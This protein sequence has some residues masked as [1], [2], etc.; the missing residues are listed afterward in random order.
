MYGG[1][2]SHRLVGHIHPFSKRTN[3]LIRAVVCVS[4]AI[5]NMTQAATALAVTPP[6]LIPFQAKLTDDQRVTVDDGV[7]SMFFAFYDAAAAGVCLWSAGNTDANTATIDCAGDTPDGTVSV[8]VTDG[9]FSLLLG[10]TGQNFIPSSLFADTSTVY[11]GLTISPDPEM[12]PRIR[13]GA[14]SYALNAESLD[15]FFPSQ[16]GGNSIVTVT[17]STGN[18]QLTNALN[19]DNTTLNRV[20]T[21]ALV[22]IDSESTADADRLFEVTS[23][24]SGDETV[25]FFL[26]SGGQTYLRSSLGINTTT[27]DGAIDIESANAGEDDVYIN[28]T[29]T[30]NGA[31]TGILT[32]SGD[33]NGGVTAARG[34]IYLDQTGV[35]WVNTSVGA[36]GSVWSNLAGAS[37]VDNFD[38]VYAESIADGN[39][40]MEIDDAGGAGLTFNITAATG[41]FVIQDAGSTF[42]RF[43]NNGNITFGADATDTVDFNADISSDFIPETDIAFDLGSAGQ[44]WRDLYL[45]PASLHIGTSATA[46]GLLT[47]TDAGQDIFNFASDATGNADIAF[48][49]DDIYLDKSAGFV[50]LGDTTPTE[51]LT[52]SGNYLVTGHGIMGNRFNGGDLG[53]V[54]F[55]DRVL[56]LAEDMTADGDEVL[57]ASSRFTATSVGFS[58]NTAGVFQATAQ[59]TSGA[60]VKLG[61]LIGTEGNAIGNIDTFGYDLATV[62]VGVNGQVVNDGTASLPTGYSFHGRPI[63][64]D[65]GDIDS[66]GAFVV[67]GPDLASSG[68]VNSFNGLLIEDL[69]GAGATET[70]PIRYLGGAG[71]VV[72]E[73]G[74]LG[75]GT[76]TPDTD[77]LATISRPEDNKFI[78]LND[79]TSGLIPGIYTGTGDPNLVINTFGGIGSIYLDQDGAGGTAWVNTDGADTWI[80]LSGG[81][82][83]TLDD[84][85]DN[86]GGGTELIEVDSG[87]LTWELASASDNFFI[88][89]IGGSIDAFT[90]NGSVVSGQAGF[91][92]INT[93]TPDARLDVEQGV[94]DAEYIRLTFGATS[95]S[96]YTGSGDPNGSVTANEGSL[97]LDQA[98]TT[99]VNTSAGSGTTWTDLAATGGAD[100]LDSVYDNDGDKT[101]DVDS[102]TGLFFD[103]TT[104]GDIAIQDASSTFALF[105]DSGNITFGAD[106]TDTVDFNADIASDFIPE[107][108][109][110]YDLGSAGQRW[111][112]LYLG[113]ATL[114]IGT[115]ATAEGLLTYTDAGQDIFNFASDATGNADIAFFV[116]DFYL[117]K[118]SGFAGFGD[119]T[120]TENLTLS[121]DFLVT[122]HGIMG[123]RFIGGDLGEVASST[124]VFHLAED[125]SADATQVL[126]VSN[127]YDASAALNS[128]MAGYFQAITAAGD[129]DGVLTLTGLESVISS[130]ATSAA[131]DIADALGINVQI[132]AQSAASITEGYG[133]RTTPIIT[134][135]G[136]ID[137]YYAFSV[138]ETSDTGAGSVGTFYGL[139]VDDLSTAASVRA[140]VLR[141]FGTNP[142]VITDTS[143][144]GIGTITPDTYIDISDAENTSLMRL[145]DETNA[146]EVDFY[147]G[148]GTPTHSAESGSLYLDQAGKAWVNSS[149]GDAGTTWTDL[150]GAGTTPDFDEVYAQSIT[151]T[152]LT[153]EVDDTTGLTFDL[154]TT[155]DF[156]I[157]DAGTP[158]ATFANTG[159]VGIGSTTPD[160][161]LD[162]ESS[163]PADQDEFLRFSDTTAGVSVGVF[164]G[165]GD[166][167]TIVTANEGSL[168]LDQAGTTWVNT[169]A[170]SGTTWVDLSAGGGGGGGWT[171]DGTLVRLTT[172]T[173]NVTVGSATNLSAQLATDG[174]ADEIQLLIQ[175]NATQTSNL[176]VV[177]N[178]G[179]ATDYFTIDGSGNGFF[180]NNID[181]GSSTADLVSVN[182]LVDT[183]ILPPTSNSLT[184]GDDTHRW[185]DLFVQPGSL[186]IGTST[187]DEGTISYDTTNNILQ[188]SSTPSLGNGTMQFIEDINGNAFFTFYNADTFGGA[189]A[190]TEDVGINF[191]VRDT[192]GTQTTIARMEAN[193]I[194]PTDTSEDAALDFSIMDDGTFSPGMRL[195][196]ESRLGIG[197]QSGSFVAPDGA[198]TVSNGTNTFDIFNLYDNTSQVFT[199]LDG[200]NVGI[201]TI[202]PAGRL[203]VIA[204]SA[205]AI[206][207]VVIDTTGIGTLTDIR[208][209]NSGTI[210]NIT[211]GAMQIEEASN[212]NALFT[213]YNSDNFGGAAAGT[214][215]IVLN[216]DT[217]D[218]TNTQ[219]TFAS[220]EGNNTDPT[221]GSEDAALDFRVMDDGTFSPG[222][223]LDDESRL[224]IGNQSGSFVA[225]DGALTVSN[226]TNTFDIF[227]LYD[228]T[229]QV[230]TVLDGGNVGIGIVAP[231]GQLHIDTNGAAVSDAI[232][233]STSS[234]SLTDA[235]EIAGA[236]TTGI[237]LSNT[238][239][240]TDISFQ[241]G[242]TLSNDING[243]F[244]FSST[245]TNGDQNILEILSTNIDVGSVFLYDNVTN[246]DALSIGKVLDITAEHSTSESSS[247]TSNTIDVRSALSG[248]VTGGTIS[249]FET[250]WTAPVG[251]GVNVTEEV[252]R[253]RNQN[254]SDAGVS[255]NNVSQLLYIDNADVDDLSDIIVDNGITIDS[256]G[257]MG[258]TNG[259]Y[260]SGTVG[261]I[262]DGIEIGTGVTTGINISG[263]QTIGL[264]FS[265]LSIG[266]DIR[267]QNGETISNGVA[268]GAFTFTSNATTGS[269]IDVVTSAI[270][271]GSI[272]NFDNVTSGDSFSIGKVLDLTAHYSTSESSTWT[273][274]TIDVRSTLSGSVTGGTISAFETLWTAPVG[275]GVNVT[276]E[277]FRIR[278]QNISDAGVSDTNVSQLLYIDNA[279]VNDLSDITVDIGLRIDST[280]DM[281][282]TNGI[283]VNSTSGTITNGLVFS[284]GAGANMTTDITLQQ[285]ETI[286]NDGTDGTIAIGATIL[287]VNGVIKTDFNGAATTNGVCHS[288]ADSDTTAT[289]REL[290][291][292][293]AAPDDI[294]EWYETTGDE[295]A[296][297]LVVATD[298]T[299]TYEAD[300]VEPLTGILTGGKIVSDLTVLDKSSTPYESRI[301]GIVSTSPAQ[302]YGRGVIDAATYPKAIATAGRVPLKVSDEN[303]AIRPG[304]PITSSST[305]GAG[306]KSTL[307]GMVVG[308][309][310]DSW[311]GPGVGTIR[312][313]V[314]PSWHSGAVIA[315]DGS[316]ATV[317]Q[318][319]AINRVIAATAVDQAQGSHALAFRGSA[320]DSSS[321]VAVDRAISIALEVTDKNEYRLSYKD[322]LD[323][324]I[325][326]LTQDGA[327]SLA[328]DL[329][330]GGNLYPSDRGT[331]QTNKYIYYDG[332]A[333]PGGDLMRT[334]ASGWGTGSYDF[335][336][337]F[338]SKDQL[339]AGDV[340]IFSVSD[341]EHV[342]RST[343]KTYDGLVAGV[344]STKPGFLAG[345]NRAG[346]FPIALAG[347]VPTKV[348]DENG[349][350]EIGDSLT[351]SSVP[352]VAMKATEDGPVIGYA[353]EPYTASSPDNLIITFINLSH[354]GGA[355][356]AP[357]DN[358]ASGISSNAQLSSLDMYGS[359]YLHG[360]HLLDVGKLVG[361][362]NTWSVDE[363]GLFATVASY[364]VVI[365]SYQNENVSAHAML[366]T[367]HSVFLSGSATLSQGEATVS[368]E[369]VDASFN[370]ITSTSSPI[371]VV[372]TANGPAYVY[373]SQKDNNGFTVRQLDG[374]DSGIVVDWHVT[375]VRKD[376]E[377]VVEEAV[378]P[379]PIEGVMPP[380]D[381]VTDPIVPPS[382][383]PADPIDPPVVEE[384]PAVEEPTVTEEP[385]LVE[386]PPVAEEPVVPPEAVIDPA[387]VPVT[388]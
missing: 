297:D 339:E 195:D 42:A 68:V 352:G 15:G 321:S 260:V 30:G 335:A 217:K 289:D 203:E 54:S 124:R 135:A 189:A 191:D 100:T 223:R 74:R 122:G 265:S 14:S 186:H 216:F 48:F 245:S 80:D 127:R 277:V 78:S 118:S 28:L 128:S 244:R 119:T 131:A 7:Y 153:M 366:T 62:L 107:T 310:L 259:L 316:V 307:P 250:L 104:T 347:R 38:E 327:M 371:S 324:E 322:S 256:T 24:V 222:M 141:Y 364:N 304:D 268:D 76:S 142:V 126:R 246:A 387:S 133:V 271:S 32:G 150:A 368:F 140:D 65:S 367:D 194:D 353:M 125:L 345:D 99:W 380:T 314:Q 211:N 381:P 151:N 372:T 359:V 363:A 385:P 167:N 70:F 35:T 288:G 311:T 89:A 60:A 298:S 331:K 279:D 138:N 43:A 139:A 206:D 342:S 18:L 254:I 41:D 3:R 91:V 45:G 261:T 251:G 67:N 166:P 66:Y 97:Y 379:P 134:A 257:G 85:Y 149:A 39:L 33:P 225:P 219:T 175:A 294:A 388:P 88:T 170:G 226:G 11:L 243:T 25:Q 94:A 187:T 21:D 361:M 275:G 69:T 29:D 214:E 235:I 269:V 79:Q 278:N 12:T 284:N 333:G 230:F 212:G 312:V 184:L 370:D 252:F 360:N 111:K 210:T 300:E 306:M 120:P 192:V 57:R 236:A 221:N 116:D 168:Y 98:G 63:I 283:V 303:G 263:A 208:L 326:Y 346:D 115:S 292:C 157:A 291:V 16:V 238:G 132:A 365:R 71:F 180:N 40:I 299:I 183:S 373:V 145:T 276:E 386:D 174:N 61:T 37:T 106:A 13:M 59:N 205:S 2:F 253:I 313:Y 17:D 332:S 233:I 44:R 349:A 50:G 202:A 376:H 173:D 201:G 232:R 204:D 382:D 200:G 108:D 160:A 92:G 178:N 334:N 227:N 295:T 188:I 318:A 182:G 185:A 228:N 336:E 172:A 266:T 56:H 9:V 199:V 234:G 218:D 47:Y 224:G 319:L 369:D 240:G 249:A 72:D 163:N 207:G 114:H 302:S 377:D 282:I 242:E 378:E 90:V 348:T 179:G 231:T 358:V 162:I 343:G 152:N 325:A 117:D 356:V 22:D 146:D 262:S 75:I 209:Q 340:V 293:S 309:A 159:F 171:D 196:D 4:V 220:I 23:D 52:V 190:G 213:L 81:S 329:W 95:A 55:T 177:E 264:N 102:A 301:V 357:I 93:A 156:K 229:S 155:G 330:I 290:V 247:W 273:S 36:T 317:E 338:P 31:S 176:V 320:W 26:T 165:S 267:L 112:D 315:N 286:D 5:I 130:E 344:V 113:P 272:F 350:I 121:G 239:I 328:G 198:L 281:G 337:M 193:S 362:G 51:N 280:G 53:E 274:N 73:G 144:L 103:L 305:A 375:A 87:D 351:T 248:S 58:G 164:T 374:M 105:D 10:D 110:F 237:H 323:Q 6:R 308:M 137:T 181:L 19:I 20:D 296:G 34:S 64:L 27:P 82:S 101:M 86:Y 383:P 83:P 287:D 77:S 129:T 258:I 143:R 147:T 8:T 84:A 169:S 255:D 1:H 96:L 158:F 154:T 197:N 270:S 109:D 354:T 341:T 46:E 215:D 241:N 384:P 49:T 285:G 161:L 136:N 355:A 123:S 148:T